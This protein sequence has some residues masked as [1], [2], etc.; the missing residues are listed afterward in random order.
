VSLI[1]A[2]ETATTAC[3]AALCAADGSVVAQS[4]TLAGPAHAERLLP[5]V[6]EVF[7][8]A[9][10]TWDDVGTV[11]VGLGPGA[12]TGLRIGIATARALVH[13]DGRL[14]LV[15]VPTLAA[16][17]LELTRSREASSGSVVVPLIDGKRR[18]VF[19]AAYVGAQGAV[20]VVED[21]VVVKADALGAW[22]A[23]HAGAVAGGDAAVLYADLL[24][25][26]I[27]AAA[28]VP[29][30]TAGMIGRAAALE[31]PGTVSGPDAVLPMYGRAPDAARW[32]SPSRPCGM[33]A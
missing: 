32:V 16:L 30:P 14:R 17:A 19:A 31:V 27:T 28:A 4:I 23:R 6:Q 1:L 7:D 10:V 9:G 11:A 5:A 22:L 33:E 26:G 2:L 15:G 8:A 12:F 25:E 21:V 18:E 20:R 29:A 24:S 13:A 3:S